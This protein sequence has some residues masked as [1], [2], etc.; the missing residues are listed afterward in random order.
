[1]PVFGAVSKV[2]DFSGVEPDSVPNM[3]DEATHGIP[4]KGPYLCEVIRLHAGLTGDQS[5]EPGSPK[6]VLGVSIAEPKGTKKAKYNGYAMWRHMTV[7]EGFAGRINAMLQA[8]MQNSKA[9][10]GDSAAA[11]KKR[12]AVINAFWN[13]PKGIQV[14]G[15]VKEGT[16][17]ITKIGT[18]VVPEDMLVGVNARNGKDRDGEPILDIG[19]TIPFTDAPKGQPADEEDLEDETDEEESEDDTDEEPEEGDEEVDARAEELDGYTLAKLKTTAKGAGLTAA[20]IK[21]LDK[22]GLVE[23]ILDAEFPAEDEPEPDEDEEEDEEEDEPEEEADEEEDDLADLSRAELKALIKEEGLE[24]RVTTK[25]SDDDLREE[26]RTA[27][28]AEDEEADEEEED[29]PEPEEAP[30]PARRGAK[31]TAAAASRPAARRRSGKK[32]EPPF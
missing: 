13:D 22:A 26:I 21:G 29:E 3:Y 23:A 10:A 31:A 17:R 27:R 2:G 8:L 20:D 19:S 11:K 1:M 28:G 15:D 12:A 4:P 6:L 30:K 18:W 14:E 7:N 5:K 32:G 24:V 25:K 16:T 9:F